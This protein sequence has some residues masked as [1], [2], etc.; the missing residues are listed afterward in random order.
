MS[1]DMGTRLSRRAGLVALGV[2]LLATGAGV[3]GVLLTRGP[4]CPMELTE[5][6]RDLG[7]PRR[8]LPSAEPHEC[9]KPVAHPD[10]NSCPARPVD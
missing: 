1:L 7:L 9:L 4:E 6:E 8:P 2:V 5:L 3:G 10:G